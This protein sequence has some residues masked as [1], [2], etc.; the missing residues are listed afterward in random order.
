MISKRIRQFGPRHRLTVIKNLEPLAYLQALA[1]APVAVGNSSSFVRDSSFFGTPV[2]LIGARQRGRENAGNVYFLVDQPL[3]YLPIVI[4][5]REPPSTLYGDGH[6]SERF[7]EALCGLTPI[8]GKQ[9]C[10]R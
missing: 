2:F 3:E 8:R 1:D 9:F 6:V 7:V 10:E 4:P 5:P